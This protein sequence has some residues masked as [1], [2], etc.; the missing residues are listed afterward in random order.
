[1]LVGVEYGCRGLGCRFSI[2]K[3]SYEVTRVRVE[4]VRMPSGPAEQGGS[5]RDVLLPNG[6]RPAVIRGVDREVL[7]AGAHVGSGPG[8]KNVVEACAVASALTWL[9]ASRCRKC[10]AKP[11]CRS[12]G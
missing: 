3:V 10:S 1:M 12:A 8:A 6:E 4:P 11:V 7:D 2:L 5:C 9:M